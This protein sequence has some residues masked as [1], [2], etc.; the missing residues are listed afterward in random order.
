MPR[1]ARRRRSLTA[2]LLQDGRV[3]ADPDE[4]ERAELE[5]LSES[6]LIAMS[7]GRYFLCT[8]HADDGDLVYA[9]DRTCH[10]KI[11]I[12]TRADGDPTQ[13]EDDLLYVCD[14]CGRTHRPI[15]R[16]RTLYARATVGVDLPAVGGWLRGLIG[17]LCPGVYSL[18][19]DAVFR[20]RH[21]G[22]EVH[23][24]VL[25][26][27]IDTRFATREFAVGNPTLYVVVAHRAFVARFPS[28]GWLSVVYLH[29]IAERGPVA[30]RQALDEL[31]GDT[32]AWAFREPAAPA[33]NP[34]RSPS[35]RVVSRTLG[36]HA[37]DLRQAPA[38][39][40]GVEV[41]P[42]DAT[43][44]L[45]ILAFFVARWREDMVAG[46]AAEDFCTYSPDEVLEDLEERGVATTESA[47]NVRR[48][49]VRLRNTV[50][51]NYL[52]QTGLAL[53]DD[54]FIE[55]VREGGYRLN[56]RSVTV[57]PT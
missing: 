13:D 50:K 33:W 3:V 24:V 31:P 35:T 14:S 38:F 30:L 54:E 47:S 28:A 57:L 12:D 17:Q 4:D 22:R 10:E 20:F 49:I 36:A 11:P 37:L 32:D 34:L 21:R 39:L 15:R 23:V 2:R 53:E 8:D 42:A 16:G 48:Q 18:R 44:S 19:D 29:E 56:P 46:K 55:T 25:D 5:R 43:G 27:C 7:W 51:R 45:E 40:D 1:P 6:G 52:R 41:L 26:A 9:R